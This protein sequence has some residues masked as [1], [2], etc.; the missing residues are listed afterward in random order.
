[1]KVNYFGEVFAVGLISF[2]MK[3]KLGN[4]KHYI[5]LTHLHISAQVNKQPSNQIAV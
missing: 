1:M 3:E 4:T 5:K 2:D